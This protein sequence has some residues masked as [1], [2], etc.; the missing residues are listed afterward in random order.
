MGSIGFKVWVQL[1]VDVVAW[2]RV[3]PC[4][5]LG[6]NWEHSPNVPARSIQFR[7]SIVWDT[8]CSTRCVGCVN[9]WSLT[10]EQRT[11]RLRVAVSK[12]HRL[13]T[14]LTGGATSRAAFPLQGGSVLLDIVFREVSLIN[15]FA[16]PMLP[17]CCKQGGRDC[18][19]SAR[20]RSLGDSD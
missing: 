9:W 13:F 12:L 16:M 15:Q 8:T 4:K 14:L 6:G 2:R 5:T 11:R 20:S 18:L 17:V 7:E 19:Q 3:L 1:R 10:S